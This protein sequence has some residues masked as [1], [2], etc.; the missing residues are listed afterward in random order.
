MHADADK[1]VLRRDLGGPRDE[2][3]RIKYREELNPAQYAAATVTSGPVLVVAGAGTGK[4]RTLVFRVARLVESGVDPAHILLLTFTR[5]A[6]A[7]ML[8]RASLLLDGRCDRVAGGTFHSFANTVLRRHGK[9]LGLAANFTI[10]DRSD[11]EDVINLLRAGLGLDKKEKRFPRKQAIA[12][13]YSMAVNKSVP[14]AQLIEE[15]YGH[16]ADH[17][18]ELLELHRRYLEY[19]TER[20][21]LDYDDLLVKLRDLLLANAEVRERLSRTYRYILVDE[22]QDTNALQAEIVRLLAAS[23]DNVMAVGDDAQSIYS[24]R[25]ANFRNIMDFPTLFPGT[26]VI[27]LEENYRSSQ[28]VLDVTNAIIAAARERYT[29]TLF[30]SKQGGVSPILVAAENEHYQSRFVCQRILELREDGTPLQDIAVLFRSSFHS[31][32]LEIEL[33][34]HDIPF[35]KRGG[36]KFIET[37]HVKDALAHLRIVVNFND[38]V[39]WHRVL[40]LLDGVGPRS[41]DEI[42]RWVLANGEQGSDPAARLES[43][44][45]RAFTTDLQALAGLVRRLHEPG[46]TPADQVEEVL[47]YY[48]PIL[49]RV[50]REDYPKRRKDLE[51]FGTI[52]ARYRSLES[53]LSDMAL[54]PPTDSVGDVLATDADEGLLTLSTVHSAKGLEWHSVFVIW[55][56]D[57]RFPSEYNVHDD[58]EIEEERRLMYVATTRTKEQLYVTY[59]IN[60][61]ERGL[62]PVLGKPSRFL[63]HI[64]PELLRPV[65]LVEEEPEAG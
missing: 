10:L 47:R 46:T 56:A 33:A 42:I 36:F 64:S 19:K 8:R 41:S 24:F 14:L 20:Q 18:P 32:D 25:G 11:S 53:L 27:A 21:L 57:G 17:L 4:T 22:Y 6:A 52:A 26:R 23:H 34:R 35:V 50:H 63:E 38:A 60:M 48:E 51:H 5:K 45:R 43:F 49:K 44:P 40:L 62:G 65:A 2:Q 30:T 28:P 31:F 13:M 12:E 3:F 37:A 29:K 59:P 54:E 15:E 16:L 39:S 58:D 9:S 61:F 1:Y 55:A 7:E